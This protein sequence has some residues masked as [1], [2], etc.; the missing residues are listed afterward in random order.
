VADKLFC[1]SLAE[2]AEAKRVHCDPG[3]DRG[4]GVRFLADGVAR[5][6]ELHRHAH[7]DL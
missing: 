4:D 1:W 3:A 7:Q 5:A 6:R 2:F